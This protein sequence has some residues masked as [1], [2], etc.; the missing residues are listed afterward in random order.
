MQAIQRYASAQVSTMA[1]IDNLQ[2]NMGSN[3]AD[4]LSRVSIQNK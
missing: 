1:G 4:T 3:N 2:G